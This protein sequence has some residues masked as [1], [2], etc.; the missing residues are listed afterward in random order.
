M[1]I[2]LMMVL[3]AIELER[4]IITLVWEQ[5]KFDPWWYPGRTVCINIITIRY[6]L[7]LLE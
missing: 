1:I 5:N 7:I 3:V 2:R 6:C 4:Q